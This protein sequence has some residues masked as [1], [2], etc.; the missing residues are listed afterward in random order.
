MTKI[1]VTKPRL[2][3]TDVLRSGAQPSILLASCGMLAVDESAKYRIKITAGSFAKTFDGNLHFYDGSVGDFHDP[4]IWKDAELPD[5]GVILIT[6]SIKIRGAWHD[7]PMIPYAGDPAEYAFLS[8]M[9][10]FYGEAFIEDQL[11]GVLGLQLQL[12]VPG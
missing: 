1:S 11:I 5:D 6:G 9:A 10:S 4:M 8:L 3:L 12:C 2:N 7:V